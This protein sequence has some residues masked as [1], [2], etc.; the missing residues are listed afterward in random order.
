MHDNTIGEEFSAFIPS[1]CS[2]NYAELNL[3]MCLA[4]RGGAQKYV[5]K[6]EATKEYI[7]EI[8]QLKKEQKSSTTIQNSL[9]EDIAAGRA[10]N[11]YVKICASWA[12]RFWLPDYDSESS[13][14]QV[15]AEPTKIFD[16]CGAIDTKAEDGSTDVPYGSVYEPWSDVVKFFNW[17]GIP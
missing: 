8:T 16:Q 6:A 5:I 7:N 9:E 10:V 17:Y 11:G 15:L 3:Y 1:P 4:C 13:N 2:G 14:F 12:R